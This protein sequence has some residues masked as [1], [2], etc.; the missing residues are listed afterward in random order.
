MPNPSGPVI[1]LTVLDTKEDIQGRASALLADRLRGF[2]FEDSDK[3]ADKASLTVDNRDLIFFE[4]EED[5]ILG[6]TLLEVSWGYLGDMS[7]PRRGIIKKVVGGEVLKVQVLAESSQLNLKGMVREWEGLTRAGVVREI[8]REH[9]YEGSSLSVEE[10]GETYEVISQQGETDA[11]FLTRLAARERFKFYIDDSG[12]HWH[13]RKFDQAPRKI[14]EYRG[15]PGSAAAQFETF[16]ISSNLARRVGKVTVKGRDPLTKKE[17][18]ASATN[19]TVDRSTLGEVIEVVDPETLGETRTIRLATE[20]IRPSGA[21]SQKRISREADARYRAAQREAVKLDLKVSGD[22]ALRAKSVVEV[23]G[24]GAAHSGLYYV[25]EAVH[26]ID[27]SGYHTSL[28][29]V[30]DGKGANGA[31]TQ[32]GSRNRQQA[33]E[34]GKKTN[35]PVEV[36]VVDPET[37]EERTEYRVL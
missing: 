5:D 36:S 17:I 19:E 27:S 2:T 18:E 3:R 16:S 34:Q 35:E 29:L 8:A 13:S 33:P 14:L 6:G 21:S 28:K 1:T 9:G 4:G 25:S 15:A 24:L 22:P 32:G 11:A 7:P 26:Q 30:R 20:V 23:R 31:E 10:T 37:L 12:L